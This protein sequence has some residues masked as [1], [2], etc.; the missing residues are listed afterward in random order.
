MT[1]LYELLVKCN[2]DMADECLKQVQL[3]IAKRLQ[4]HLW[5]TTPDYYIQLV[6]LFSK[7]RGQPDLNWK[8]YLILAW[9]IED[10]VFKYWLTESDTSLEMRTWL[11]TLQNGF[12][13]QLTGHRAD[14]QTFS[15]IQISS[16][17]RFEQ[18]ACVFACLMR[19]IFRL[20]VPSH[21]CSPLDVH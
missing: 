6:D 1:K 12:H 13:F 18:H 4:K 2:H 21:P 15:V 8:T 16:I 3:A 17:Q 11:V 10:E 5:E 20:D 9:M 7:Q 19:D 14:G